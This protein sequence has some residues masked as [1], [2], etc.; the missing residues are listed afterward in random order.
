MRAPPLNNSC[1]A[2]ALPWVS[3][4]DEAFTAGGREGRKECSHTVGTCLAMTFQGLLNLA[5]TSS[6]F[7]DSGG[8]AAWRKEMMGESALF[9]VLFSVER[10]TPGGAGTHAASSKSRKGFS[11]DHDAQQEARAEPEPPRPP[12]LMSFKGDY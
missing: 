4:T 1:V 10:L 11:C 9:L 3:R 8:G 7:H 12:T 5:S 6:D 2:L